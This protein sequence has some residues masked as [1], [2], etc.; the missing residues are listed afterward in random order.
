[1]MNNNNIEMIKRLQKAAGY[2]KRAI[3]ALFPDMMNEHFDVIEKE[4]KL[5]MI[6]AVCEMQKSRKRRADSFRDFFTENFMGSFAGNFRKDCSGNENNEEIREYDQA[7]EY[8][9]AFQGE[10][11]QRSAGHGVTPPAYGKK[12]GTKKVTI[13]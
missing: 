10:T 4:L 11:S 13:S 5:M 8:N 6:E 2:Q 3:Q 12:S 1:M 9:R 7:E